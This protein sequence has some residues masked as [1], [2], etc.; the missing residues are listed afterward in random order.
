MNE[1]MTYL[2]ALESLQR[3][4]QEL[5][6][7]FASREASF[8]LAMIDLRGENERLAS[9]ITKKEVR[10]NKNCTWKDV[11]FVQEDAEMIDLQMRLIEDEKFELGNEKLE[12]EQLLQEEQVTF[13]KIRRLPLTFQSQGCIKCKK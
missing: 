1:K 6:L 3:E 10:F 13:L 7:R 4:C 2:E 5:K 11:N 8:E 9:L 12:L